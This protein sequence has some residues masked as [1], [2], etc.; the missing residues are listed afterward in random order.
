MPNELNTA[1][2]NM[3]R[4]RKP[5]LQQGLAAIFMAGCF[6]VAGLM[7]PHKTWFDHI[8]RPEFK[9]VIPKQFGDWVDN[10]DP[11]AGFVIDPQQED[12]LAALYTEVVSRIYV[13]KATGRRIMLSL[14]YGDIQT[15][16]QQLHRPEA[17]YS[18]QGFNIQNLHEEQLRAAGEPISVYRMTATAGGRLEQVTYWIRIGDKVISG[19]PTSLNIARMTMGL[20]GYVADGL[21]FRVSELSDDAKSSNLL[22]NQFINDLLHALSPAQQAML[23]AQST[24]K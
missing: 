24:A 3:P 11:N 19:P 6:A 22:Q 13:N 20:K 2:M 17:C 15:Y 10:G 12:A 21:L 14:A 4:V 8:G 5:S 16:A 23:I 1:E 9:N 18:S 7:A